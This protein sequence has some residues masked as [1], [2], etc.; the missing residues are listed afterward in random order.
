MKTI[1]V[2]RHAKSSWENAGLNDFDRPLNERGKRDAPRMGKRL[3]ER[4][5]HPD[6]MLT[7]PAKRAW[8]TCKRIAETLGYPKGNIQTEQNLY[9][10]D[11]DEILSVVQKIPETVNNLMI[12]GHNP[13]LTDFVNS[14]SPK[15][16]YIDNVPTCGVVS[17][18][19]N[20]KSWQE[21]NFQK[22]EFQFFDFPKNKVN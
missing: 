8:S 6:L 20:V 21:V 1:F 7:S 10:A 17:F 12:F 22:G 5:I 4:S 16:N 18:K 2:I 3:K 11:E 19:F 14:L 15:D 9:H 13:G